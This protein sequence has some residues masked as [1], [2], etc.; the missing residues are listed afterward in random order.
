MVD[1]RLCLKFQEDQRHCLLSWTPDG[2]ES[3]SALPKKFKKTLPKGPDALY[4]A[5]CRSENETWLPLLEKAYAKAHLSY[6]SVEGGWTGEGVED[7]TGG[8]NSTLRSEDILDR[9]TLWAELQ[10]VNKEFLFGCGSRRALYADDYEDEP[11]GVVTSHAYT[12]L[13]AKEIKH[14]VGKDKKEEKTVRLLKVRNPWGC[15]EWNGAW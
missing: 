11:T 13:K 1:D 4:F 9:D 5:S 8:V 7:L 15:G 2:R 10:Q 6:Q 12:V 3:K 14:K